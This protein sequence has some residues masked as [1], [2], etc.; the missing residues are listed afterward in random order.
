M[1]RHGFRYTTLE[2]PCVLVWRGQLLMLLGP[3]PC[4]APRANIVDGGSTARL[5]DRF[6]SCC[7]SYASHGSLVIFMCPL[8]SD[9]EDVSFRGPSFS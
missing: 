1:A 9:R 4:D 5:I 2:L 6:R 3:M 7:C 8:A